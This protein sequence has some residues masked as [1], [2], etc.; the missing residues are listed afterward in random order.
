M[1]IKQTWRK[2]I[3]YEASKG[4]G[5]SIL[6][7]CQEY[8]LYNEVFFRVLMAV[9]IYLRK[10]LWA[11]CLL[12]ALLNMMVVMMLM[13]MLTTHDGDG[14]DDDDDYDDEDDDVDE[15]EDDS[16]DEDDGG[17]GGYVKN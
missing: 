10:L 15:D 17:D 14:E 6:I 2:S 7:S 13:K 3:C 12:F 9:T 16:D 11:S 8:N 5:R 4:W 1:M